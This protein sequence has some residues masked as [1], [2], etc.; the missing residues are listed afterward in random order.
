MTP[1]PREQYAQKINQACLI[2]DLASRYRKIDYILHLMRR[3]RNVPHL[4]LCAFLQDYARLI[5][6]I[7]K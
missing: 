4:V 7:P 6:E 2:N 1:S 3:D 5:K